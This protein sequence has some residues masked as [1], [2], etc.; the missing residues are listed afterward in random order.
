MIE[1]IYRE[2]IGSRAYGDYIGDIHGIY[3]EHRGSI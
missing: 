3:M 2:Y 1:G